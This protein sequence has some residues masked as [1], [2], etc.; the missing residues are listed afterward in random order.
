[1]AHTTLK[2]LVDKA[3]ARVIDTDFIR[4]DEQFWVDSIQDAI[5]A[6]LVIR[7]DAYVEMT[8]FSC[9]EGTEQGLPDDVNLLMNVLMNIGGKAV[10]GPHDMLMLDNYRPDWRTEPLKDAVD[11]YFYDERNPQVFHVYPPVNVGTELRLVVSVTPPA[12]TIT[13]YNGGQS[14]QLSPLFD[15]PIVEYMVYLAFSQDNEFTA[16]A[17]KAQLSLNAFNSLLGNKN[18][19][20]AQY[21][22]INQLNQ[23]KPR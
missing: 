10:R 18:A 5:K 9:D 7:P 21:S 17:S 23:N 3:A 6:I 2:A 13:D 20:D 1:M 11:T 22:T 16:N 4:W 19:S 14:S 15:N 8:N 12:P